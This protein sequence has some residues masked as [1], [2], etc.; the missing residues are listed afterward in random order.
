MCAEVAGT[1]STAPRSPR[2]TA[3]GRSAVQTVEVT[4]A[5]VTV[6][7]ACMLEENMHG[8]TVAPRYGA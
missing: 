8:V 5:S 3:L 7:N 4:E 2:A 6:S 1:A